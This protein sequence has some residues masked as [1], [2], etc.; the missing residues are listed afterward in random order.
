MTFLGKLFVMVNVAVS[1]FM[2]FAAFGLY[3]NTVDWGYDAAKPGQAGGVIKEK[4]AEIKE[5]T[6]MQGP[7]ENAWKQARTTLADA[8]QARRDDKAFFA[9]ELNHLTSVAQ[10]EVPKAGPARE[11]KFKDL[12]PVRDAK[13]GRPEMKPDAKV[14]GD[15]DK[16]AELPS[17]YSRAYYRGQFEKHQATNL[18]LLD[19]LEKET[20]KDIIETN[21]MLDDRDRKMSV[22]KDGKEPKG[23]RGLQSLLVEERKKREGIEREQRLVRPLYINVAVENELIL[24]RLESLEERIKELETYIRKRKMDVELTRR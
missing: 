17:L 19:K 18:E 23:W 9:S 1:L 8:E 11:I 3:A 5:F 12:L 16:E 24:K 6:T 22:D 10:P 21:K 2:A 4:Q 7:V 15:R 13:T 14:R 20:R